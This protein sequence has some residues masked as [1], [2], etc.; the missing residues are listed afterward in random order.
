MEAG[1]RRP[2]KVGLLFATW[3]YPSTGVVTQW[4]DVRERILRAEELGFDS[5]W[6]VDHFLFRHPPEP[7]AGFWDGWSCLAAIAEA[8]TRVELGLLVACTAY[9]HPVILAKAAD[10]IDEI[11]GGRT[12]L[13]IGAGW[14][15]TEFQ[16]L[17][18]PY[19][20]R[21]SRFEEALTM[22]ATLLREGKIDFEGQ[23]YQARECELRPRGPRPKGPPIMVG[24]T[25][26]RMIRLAAR[27]AD[28]LNRDFGPTSHADLE[29]WHARVDAACSTV[30]R[31]PSTLERTVAVAINLPNAGST[32]PREALTGS[33]EEL[34]KSLRAIAADGVTHV[35]IW[36]EP[37]TLAG[38][39]AFA[40]TL[41]I[42][43]RAE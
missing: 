33:P 1:S 25:R 38:I 24:A 21:V 7:T 29:A 10:T 27:H 3:E 2:L 41:E 9:R 31:D 20:H 34:A 13:G 15:E 12:I 16:A 11:S 17:G 23:Y 35:Q 18:A 5:A 36:L 42:L 43:D 39:E 22:I 6:L 4:R 30:G 40:P 8:T 14:T 37:A 32:I 26:D 28:I 19:D